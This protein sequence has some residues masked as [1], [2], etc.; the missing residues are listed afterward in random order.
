MVNKIQGAL[1]LSVICIVISLISAIMSE[2]WLVDSG[3]LLLVKTPK[4]IPLISAAAFFIIFTSITIYSVTKKSLLFYSQA[5]I[6]IIAFLFELYF[7]FKWLIQPTNFFGNIHSQWKNSYNTYLVSPVQFKLKCCG[8]YD[9]TEFKD[10][11][12]TDSKKNSCFS[13]L[14]KAFRFNVRSGGLF[15]IIFFICQIITEYLFYQTL[16]E[17]RVQTRAVGKMYAKA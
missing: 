9:V 14:D 4:Y 10:D 8:F 5:A 13:S 3:L 6:S 16:N 11:N 15:L 12:C 17:E 2:S 1:T 7:G